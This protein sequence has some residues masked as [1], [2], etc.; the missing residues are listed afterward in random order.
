MRWVI[1]AALGIQVTDCGQART[2]ER[3]GWAAIT[4]SGLTEAEGAGAELWGC[5]GVEMGDGRGAGA[6]VG[7]VWVKTAPRGR[8]PRS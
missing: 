3:G 1:T 7:G 2:R 5:V 8:G 4:R 6:G